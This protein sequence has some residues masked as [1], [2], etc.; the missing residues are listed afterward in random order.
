MHSAQWL[1]N[2]NIEPLALQIQHLRTHSL[3]VAG[4]VLALS[5][6]VYSNINYNDSDAP[7]SRLTPVLET[8]AGNLLPW[9]G[10]QTTWRTGH[11][12]LLAGGS[13]ISGHCKWP[14]ESA[15]K[16]FIKPCHKSRK[17]GQHPDTPDKQ[18]KAVRAEGLL[19]VCDEERKH[20]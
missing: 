19:L 5:F 6:A 7:T 13:E 9:Q 15:L 10:A 2:P 4:A 12:Q 8:A 3:T 20:P 16:H 11:C 17:I 18:T 1:C 14:Q